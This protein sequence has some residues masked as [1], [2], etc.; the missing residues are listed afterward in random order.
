MQEQ[1]LTNSF[2]S[3]ELCSD[4]CQYGSCKESVVC[5]NSV[6]TSE[7]T[8][9]DFYVDNRT[10]II[11]ILVGCW[12]LLVLFILFFFC[13][14][15]LAQERQQSKQNKVVVN[16]VTTI[17]HNCWTEISNGESLKSDDFSVQLERPVKIYNKKPSPSAFVLPQQLPNYCL[18]QLPVV[19]YNNG[20]K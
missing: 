1:Q 8:C 12:V 17:P 3:S 5:N 4:K 13:Q 16:N 18:M 7:Y 11:S 6:C 19:D 10:I 2:N 20:T 15:K 14:K 9:Q